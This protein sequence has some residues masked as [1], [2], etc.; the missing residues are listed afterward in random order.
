M[1]VKY[2]ASLIADPTRLQRTSLRSIFRR[3]V[4][5]VLGTHLISLTTLAGCSSD[6][7]GPTAKNGAA[8]SILLSMDLA[9][10]LTSGNANGTLA[11]PSDYDDAWALA[12][13]RDASSTN[14][15]GIVVT[16]GNGPLG[17][18]MVTAKETLA[19]LELNVPLVAGA[20]SWL[21]VV[22]TE[23]Y[24]GVD[25]SPTCVNEGVEFMA[26]TL[27]KT[28]NVTI[29][30]TG[31][32]T[33]VACLVMAFPEQA[34]NITEVITLIG[35]APDGLV[36]AGKPV[37]D[38]NF[39]MDPRALS[40]LVNES[41]IPFVAVTFE[42]SSSTALS[43]EILDALATDESPTA[44]YFGRASQA[45]NT[46]WTS[47]FGPTKPVW[48]ASAVWRYLHPEDFVCEAARFELTLGAPNLPTTETHDW[49]V[50][51]PE[52]DGRVQACI[53]FTSPAAIHR[54]NEAV[55]T[56]IRK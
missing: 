33:D 44:Q 53:S 36:Y 52:S 31:P 3:Y 5:S 47:I 50:P 11:T 49:L 20:A 21:P 24:S 18:S 16:M 8:H 1:R 48:D 26:E 40:V 4:L 22:A 27:R 28:K 29:V 23:D 6:A 43:T 37:R 12:L 32:L 41:V 35:S 10:G 17:P 2:R 7:V 25:L 39:S 14:V 55:L 15:L 56:A 54:M 9:M 13:L 45:Y 51:D 46:W 30:A 42:A 19:A 34:A 38:F